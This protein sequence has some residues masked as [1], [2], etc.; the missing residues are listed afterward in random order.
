MRPDLL[1][2]EPKRLASLLTPGPG[3]LDE[4]IRAAEAEAIERLVAA[5]A[6]GQ[7]GDVLQLA[8]RIGLNKALPDGRHPG[9]TPLMAAAERGRVEV[10]KLLVEKRASLEIT[11]PSGWTALMHAVQGQRPDAVSLLLESSAAV[12]AVAKADGGVTPLMLAAG[13][14]RPELCD[15]LLA[16]GASVGLRDEEGRRPLHYAA[17]KGN[18]G[19]LLSLLRAK[20]KV[21]DR[22]VDGLTALLV[23]ASAGRTES[24]RILLA[25]RADVHATD[26]MGR[27]A[28]K[29]A[30]IYEHDRVLRVLQ[31]AGG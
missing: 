4:E 19:A 17:K 13:A 6:A 12:N 14:A 30:G 7:T 8:A 9:M 5:A 18:N 26:R 11:D 28:S 1:T 25:N 2:G 24:V 15:A 29:I 3:A 21:E 20:A 22:T 23:A 10:V 27:P 31:E 16:A